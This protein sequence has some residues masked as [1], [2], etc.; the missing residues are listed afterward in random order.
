LSKLDLKPFFFAWRDNA[1]YTLADEA[2]VLITL[3][4]LSY[5]KSIE[6]KCLIK[7]TL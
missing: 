6:E 2:K 4:D 3:E 1:D 5:F 7:L